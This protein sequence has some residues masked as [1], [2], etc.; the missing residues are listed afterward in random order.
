MPAK[1]G[2]VRQAVPFR[3]VTTD[4]GGGLRLCRYD[5]FGEA[6]KS[7]GSIP[8]IFHPIS[9]CIAFCNGLP[10]DERVGQGVDRLVAHLGGFSNI[11]EALLFPSAV[12]RWEP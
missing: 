1:P 2:P 4:L 6:I 5:D 3:G 11:R 8:M 7:R 10:S 12:R 9:Y